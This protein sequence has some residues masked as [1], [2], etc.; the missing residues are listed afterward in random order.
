M[1]KNLIKMS[2]LFAII[3]SFI[4]ITIFIA[5]NFTVPYVY[6]VDGIGP[7]IVLLVISIIS[8]I[9]MLVGLMF[10]HYSKLP[11]KMIKENKNV[12]LVWAF[13][14]FILNPL[15]SVFAFLTYFSMLDIKIYNNDIKIDYIEE[16]KEL[17]KLKD[18]GYITDK[19]FQ[20]K[21]KNILDI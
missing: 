20:A 9:Y 11:D 21:K 2:G 7:Y 6:L 3:F 16:I 19:E 10:I 8:I 15:A 5:V 14:L 1:S 18:E 17:K 13:L 12:I 4:N